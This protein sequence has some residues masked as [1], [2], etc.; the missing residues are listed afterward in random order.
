MINNREQLIVEFKTLLSQQTNVPKLIENKNIF[1][2]KNVA[3]LYTQLKA[4]PP[5]QRRDAGLEINA[6]NEELTKLFEE[7]KA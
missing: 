2:K 7:K 6:F 3:N 5:E 1:F 4:L